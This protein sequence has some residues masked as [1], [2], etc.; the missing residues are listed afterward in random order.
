VTTAMKVRETRALIKHELQRYPRGDAPQNLFRVLYEMTRVQGL[1]RRSAVPGTADSAHESA[2]E[3]VRKQYPD[4]EPE[5][6][7][8][9]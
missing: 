5:V 7:D 1:D 9:D 3:T 4:F 8:P 2:L 6:I